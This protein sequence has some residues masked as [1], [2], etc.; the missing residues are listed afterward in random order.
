MSHCRSSSSRASAGISGGGMAQG[1]VFSVRVLICKSRRNRCVTWCVTFMVGI[2]ERRFLTSISVVPEFLLRP[3]LRSAG[4]NRA[5]LARS[6]VIAECRDAG[7]TTAMCLMLQD[8]EI[9][10]HGSVLPP[11]K[12][13][14]MTANSPLDH[15][16]KSARCVDQDRYFDRVDS[17]LAPRRTLAS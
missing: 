13:P 8:A 5:W 11:R 7:H 9:H 4:V 3:L 2:L 6:T 16:V 17:N 10:C 15:G 12:S 14:H 1:G